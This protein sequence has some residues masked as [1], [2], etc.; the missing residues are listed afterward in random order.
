MAQD[1]T[2]FEKSLIGGLLC[3]P[4]Q[5]A[6]C[7]REGVT[8]GWFTVDAWGLLYSALLEC[9]ERGELE[10][11]EPLALKA[12]AERIAKREGERREASGLTLDAIQAAIDGGTVRG[13]EIAIRNL[14]GFYLE[15]RMLAV[16][17]SAKERAETS[18]NVVEIVSRVRSEMERIEADAAAPGDA[19]DQVTFAAIKDP[20]D[21]AD[22]DAVIFKNHYFRKGH[23]LFI[24]S[25]SGAG[26][27]VFV[28]QL[29]LFMAAGREFLGMI[30][31][32]RL[33]VGVVQAE[34]DAQ[35]MADFRRN[36]KTGL[37]DDYG[38]SEADF[39]GAQ[40]GKAAY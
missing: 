21:E 27:S 4:Q 15:R 40:A 3:D 32:K 11:A 39:S 2:E 12:D 24:V 33:R 25:T 8:P 30:P 35:E 36:L 9:N 7:K 34:D 38:W 20:P 26:K 14:R 23:A 6:T 5:L 1:F 18:S 10:K 31:R 37:V 17:K 22:D 29:S 19:P 28:N 16:F 13:V